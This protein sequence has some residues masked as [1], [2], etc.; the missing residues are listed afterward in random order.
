MELVDIKKLRE[1][2]QSLW[3]AFTGIDGD[4][5]RS[6]RLPGILISLSAALLTDD[7]RLGSEDYTGSQCL[8]P[9]QRQLQSYHHHSDIQTKAFS[10]YVN[11]FE[12]V[13]F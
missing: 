8:R 2:I 7:T 12:C 11:L 5:W 13:I 10:F 4:K 3:G 9:R 1:H 6:E